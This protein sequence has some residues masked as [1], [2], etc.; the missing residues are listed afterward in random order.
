[1]GNVAQGISAVRQP[2]MNYPF[3]VGSLSQATTGTML[4]SG[5]TG[6]S[7]RLMPSRGSVYGL[8]GAYSTALTAGTVTLTPVINGT[9]VPALAVSNKAAS[10]KG[11][12]GLF[13]ARIANFQA[14]DTLAIVYT[15]SGLN[16]AGGALVV[17][18]YVFFEDID[19]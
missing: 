7:V 8:A 19:I 11:V 4:P 9:P 2:Q 1:M 10:A 16:A 18:T 17:D 5:I 14:G 13:P 6:Q 3:S 12:Y 15:T